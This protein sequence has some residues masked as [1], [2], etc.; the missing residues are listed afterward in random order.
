MHRRF[1]E[2][3]RTITARMPVFSSA[4][5]FFGWLEAYAGRRDQA[6]P[7]ALHLPEVTLAV[8]MAVIGSL[9][10]LLRA[11]NDSLASLTFPV[12]EAP[13][14]FDRVERMLRSLDKLQSL[15]LNGG[16]R[17]GEV[18]DS[19]HDLACVLGSLASA[20]TLIALRLSY[21]RFDGTAV[22]AL[23]RLRQL[24]LM[25]VVGTAEFLTA[26]APAAAGLRLLGV[27]GSGGR[28]AVDTLE[29][30]T[31]IASRLIGIDLWLLP[32]VGDVGTDEGRRALRR[33]RD[34]T[35]AQAHAL[36][37]LSVHDHELVP[38]PGALPDLV[39]LSIEDLPRRS[40]VDEEP[41][42]IRA[43]FHRIGTSS[44]LRRLAFRASDDFTS[45]IEVRH[46][47]S[48]GSTERSGDLAGAES[49][50]R[51]PA[52]QAT[53]RGR[54]GV[55]LRSVRRATLVHTLSGLA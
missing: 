38:P 39:E 37:C 44:S 49:G 4:A 32:H 6:Q 33:A 17:P 50:A 1:A 20:P 25:D 8:G 12:P 9:V 3:V 54:A 13:V 21:V 42:L 24:E 5:N 15:A 23:P 10:L 52:P 47:S 51:H 40:D 43:L 35:Y 46:A 31:S 28:L 34:D 19:E 18:E 22:A 16:G 14:L 48:Q 45:E 36:R 53:L 2:A 29:A 41:A 7:S 55:A 30:I 27:S 26:L 11:I